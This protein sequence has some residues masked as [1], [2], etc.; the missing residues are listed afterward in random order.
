MTGTRR[1]I[2]TVTLRSAAPHRGAEA[3]RQTARDV[4]MRLLARI[5]VLHGL[6]G[7][8]VFAFIQLR[9]PASEAYDAPWVN[10]LLLVLVTQAALAPVAWAW[11]AREFRNSAG[12]ALSG[13][14]P[15]PRERERVLGEPFRMATLP[16]VFWVLAAVVIGAA[17]GARRV[18]G[19]SEIFDIGQIMVMGGLAT[20]AISYLV[21]ERT[22]RPLFA[23]A[24]SG[25]EITRP[26]TLGVRARLLL[27]WAASSGVP[28]LGLTLT[29]FR[30]TATS[31]EALVALGLIGILAGLFAVA[32][33]ADSIAAPLDDI[34]SALARVGKG[35]LSQD[36]LVD[37][38][39]EVGQVQAGFNQ[40]VHGLRERQQLQ[41]LFGRH[42]GHEVAAQAIERGSDLGGEARR[43]SVMFVDL[44]GSTAMAEV[45]PPGE[46]VATLNAFFDAVVQAVTDEGG[47]VNK[48][49]GDGALCVFGVPGFQPD[50]EQRALRAA[51]ALHACLD[52]LAAEHPGLDAGI[53]VSSGVVVAGNIGTE[54]RFE[55]TVIGRAVNEAARLTGLA[56]QRPGRVLASAAAVEAAGPERANWI[57]RGHVGL[58]G[59]QAPTSVYEVRPAEALSR[60]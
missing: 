1:S 9:Y 26:R 22:F 56:Q 8:I 47:W 51:R 34:R 54:S 31:N 53:G 49:Q 6:G 33:A 27:A 14:A 43:A 38:G 24:L 48:F 40:M 36:L 2:A 10:D 23:I 41:D 30:E 18:F 20:C 35:D 11:V 58:R 57:D 28:L 46:V 19:F 5:S 55:Y 21:I 39:G 3:L 13:R 37:D 17:V 52:D 25:A 42:V 50:H 32:V 45:L 29:P 60:A 4:R 7:L 15:N 44:I 16:L 12:W 59:Q